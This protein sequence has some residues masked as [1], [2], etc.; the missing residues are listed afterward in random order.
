[1]EHLAPFWRYVWLFLFGSGYLYLVACGTDCLRSV[2]L[3]DKPILI[4]WDYHP[5]EKRIL[6]TFMFI[7]F[8]GAA[9]I[10]RFCFMA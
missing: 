10:V 5:A 7:I 8:F 3:K 2:V 4:N 9:S 1:M 6:R